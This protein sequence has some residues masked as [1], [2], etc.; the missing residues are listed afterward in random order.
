M[1][2]HLSLRVLL[3]I[4][5]FSTI[6]VSIPQS[7]G[8]RLIHLATVSA[9]YKPG[10]DRLAREYM[11]LHPEVE[12]KINLITGEFATWVRTQIAGGEQTAP[13]IY[14]ANYTEGYYELGK[15]VNLT[16]YLNHINPYT[17][18]PWRDSLSEPFLEKYKSGGRDVCTIP[19]D[20]VEIAFFYNKNMFQ[21]L[22]IQPPET[23]EELIAICKKIQAAGYIPVAIPGNADSYWAGVVGWIVRFFTDAYTRDYVPLCMS[24]PG[25]WDYNAARN[26]NFKLNLSDPY[27]DA[28]LIINGERKLQLVLDG[29]LRFDTPRF[30]ELYTYIRE[31][32]QY[33]QPGFNGTNAGSAYQLFLM[34][35]AA[36]FIDGS[37]RISGLKEDMLD[38]EPQDRFAWSVFRLPPLTS[39]KYRLAP[40][41]GVGGAGTVWC[42]VKKS[43]E[44]NKA[45][46]DFLMFITTPHAGKVLVEEVSKNRL[47]LSGPML[48]RGV[49]LP[50]EIKDQFAAF[51]GLG[52]EK[53]SFR[54]WEDEQESV[55][56]WTVYAQTYL[57]GKMSLSEF[58]SRYQNL[59][60]A[61][62]NRWQQKYQLDLN[63]KTKD[64]IKF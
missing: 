7:F 9:G 61:A 48:I 35:K 40:F 15:W 54:G 21:K 10:L 20:F 16:P 32:A 36:M 1:K 50:P 28:T 47:P 63:P 23:W 58:L 12:V 49:E 38:L 43:P 22:G 34:Q 14:N 42:V 18:Q 5:S 27:N 19:I 13:D 53:L 25:D 31:F 59:M 24:Q 6:P 57:A 30:K 51:E 17:D 29:K 60:V 33:W 8:K 64:E 55:W 44:Q 2:L 37:W 52:F 3:I 62:A 56:Q 46:I 45:V 26:G 11:K 41:R 4:I 39:G